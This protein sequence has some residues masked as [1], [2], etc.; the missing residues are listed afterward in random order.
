MSLLA[1]SNS[2]VIAFIALELFS[3]ALYVLVAI[4]VDALPGLE[5]ALK[6]LIVGSVGAAFLLYGSALVYGATGQFEFDLI[7]Q[8][9]RHGDAH[10][11]VLL[12]GV[13]MIIV[14]L[15]FKANSAPFHMWTPDAYEG[16]P[17]PVTAFMSAATK[18]VAL[19]LTFRVLVAAFGEDSAI[20]QDAIGAL[21]VVSFAVGNLAALRQANVKRM[22]AYSTIG[23]TGFLF[24]AV[25][26]HTQAAARAMFYYLAIYSLMNIGA[27]ALVAIRER[28]LGRPVADRRLPRLRLPA[29]A[30]GDLDG[31]VHAVAGRAAADGRV[32]RQDHDLEQR[33]RRRADVPGRRG[34]GRD[35]GRARLLPEDPVRAGRPG[36]AGPGVAI[37]SGVRRNI[38][39][40]IGNGGRGDGARDHSRAAPR[41]GADGKCITDREM[42]MK[43][44]AAVAVGALAIVVLF[45]ATASARTLSQGMCGSDV[46]H[47][48]HE[49]GLHKYLPASYTP[50]CYDYRTVAGRDGLPGLGPADARRRGRTDSPRRVSKKAVTPRP[51][52]GHR[53]FA[54]VEVHKGRQVLLLIGKLGK[55]RR[56]IHVSTAAPGHVTPTGHWHV[57][58]K[59]RMSWSIPFHVWL[60]W[61]SYIVGGIAMHSF[62]SVPGYPAS[63]GCIRMPA[64]EARWMYKRTPIGTP[65]WVK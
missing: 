46:H 61:A 3:I 34:R 17:T 50:G 36:C 20:W 54:H 1:V 45:P 12:L 21:A 33:R 64:P 65:V 6:Y 4:D 62:A 28:E 43:R 44:L 48:Q 38:G 41:S 55:V 8:S 52:T 16:A 22:L 30:A 59:S 25:A 2:L 58:S 56:A 29:A 39:Y 14:G 35:P 32:H 31:G 27:F 37:S 15:G 24:T 11:G 53:H 10:G 5:G 60:P 42:T 19:V 7:A 18:T 26:V 13:A 49:L 63:H 40:R 57:Y 51:W 47:L 9:I 23:H